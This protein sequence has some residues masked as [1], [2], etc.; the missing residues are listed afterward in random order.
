M[1]FERFSDAGRR[2]VVLAQE[3]ARQLRHDEIGTEHLLLGLLDQDTTA[4]RILGEMQVGP[5]EVRERVVEVVG[6]G[7]KRRR[8]QLPFTERA[9]RSLEIAAGEPRRAGRGRVGPEQ[10]LQGMLAQAE[11]VGVVILEDLGVDLVLLRQRL[12]AAGELPADRP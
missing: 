7:R 11:G 2:T 4:A 6:K 9:K 5:A 12:S 1:V 8:G 10:V 3:Q